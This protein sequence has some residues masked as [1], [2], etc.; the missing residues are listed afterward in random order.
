MGF[1]V[2]QAVNIIYLLTIA[3]GLAAFLL[4]SLPVFLAILVFF[5]IVIIMIIISILMFMGKRNKNPKE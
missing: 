3:I 5:Q 1:N 2:P 4:P